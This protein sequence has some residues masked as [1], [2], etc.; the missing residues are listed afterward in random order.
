M[1]HSQIQEVPKSN[2]WLKIK[3]KKSIDRKEN[4]SYFLNKR[5]S[6]KYAKVFFNN[7]R[8]IEIQRSYEDA[9]SFPLAMVIIK[10]CNPVNGPVCP[11]VGVLYKATSAI[12]ESDKAAPHGNASKSN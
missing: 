12:T 9:K 11:Y 4:D 1:V 10:V 2:T 3:N 5:N 6:N 8:V 7:D